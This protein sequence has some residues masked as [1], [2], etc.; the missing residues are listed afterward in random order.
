MQTEEIVKEQILKWIENKSDNFLISPMLGDASSRRY[1]RVQGKK[2]SFLACYDPNPDS[3]NDFIKIQ[4]YLKKIKIKVPEIIK[5]QED[6]Q[7]LLLEDLGDQTFLISLSQEGLNEECR[8]YKQA[9]DLIIKMQKEKWETIPSVV[10]K[11]FFD[12][13]KFEYEVNMTQKYFVEGMLKI[14]TE[15]VQ[16]IQQSFHKIIEKIVQE[17]NVFCH[18]DFHSRNLMVSKEGKISVIDFQDARMGA[19]TYD[20]VSLL[21]DCY[22][23]IDNENRKEL[24]KYYWDNSPKELFISDSFEDFWESYHLMALQRVFKAIGSFCYIYKNRQDIR[25]LKYIGFAMEKI[26]RSLRELRVKSS[27]TETLLRPYYES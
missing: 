15:Q 20:L 8:F 25:Y 22:I 14:P 12:R 26:K 27:L 6:Q 24:I 2:E 7:M 23:D 17:K 16:R 1:W 19:P 3:F 9:I 11:R 10:Q 4:N 21:E 13:E 18:R 5:I